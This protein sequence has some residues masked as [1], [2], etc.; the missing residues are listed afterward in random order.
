LNACGSAKKRAMELLE[1]ENYEEAA[2]QLE[3]L[4]Q[5]EPDDIELPALLQQARNGA[6]DKRLIAVRMER[7]AGNSDG[8]LEKL[9]TTF[10]QQRAWKMAMNPKLAFTAEEETQLAWPA[11]EKSVD[12]AVQ[13][14]HPLKS[15]WRLRRYQFIFTGDPK[16]AN[17]LTALAKNSREAGTRTCQELTKGAAA[18][19]PWQSEFVARICSFFAADANAPRLTAEARKLKAK[20]Q[21]RGVEITEGLAGLNPGEQAPIRGA[22]TQAFENSPY[23][24]AEAQGPVAFPLNGSLTNTIQRKPVQLSHGYTVKEEYIDYETVTK[25]RKVPFKNTYLEETYTEQEKV[26]KQREVPKIYQFEGIHTDQSLQLTVTSSPQ[27][28]SRS[29]AF[30]FQK[31]ATVSGD[32][33]SVRNSAIGLS[34]VR[35]NL[36]DPQGFIQSHQNSLRDHL[37]SSL[38]AHWKQSYCSPSAPLAGEDSADL[39]KLNPIMISGERV[40]VCLHGLQKGEP[41]PGFAEDWYRNQLDITIQEGREVLDGDR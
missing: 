11:F 13:A 32:E 31:A 33:H 20:R 23:F 9:K 29:L 35:L 41:A 37:Q 39:G 5:K 25:K 22:I 28:D 26:K 1:K 6:I 2:A 12:T 19:L 15:E 34:P 3:T 27:L 14:G 10:D 18:E 7:L 4:I 38:F 30:N 40:Q 16:R 17:R 24:S 8:A 36:I 21:Y